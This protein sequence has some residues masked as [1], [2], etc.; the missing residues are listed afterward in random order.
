MEKNVILL[1]EDDFLN[2]RLTKKI[3]LEGDYL[4]FEGKNKREAMDILNSHH[5]DLAILDINLGSD[6]VDGIRLGREVQDR[7]KIPL[8]YLTAY[9]NSQVINRAIQTD[10]YAYLTKPFKPIDLITT[11]ELALKHIIIS[12][13]AQPTIQ[14]KEDDYT[15]DLPISSI[16][17]I[18]SNGNYLL[19]HT[20]EKTYKN[21]LTMKQ[22]LALLPPES[23]LQI[24]RA[25]VVNKAKIE[26]FN[27]KS[28]MVGNKIIPLSR[29]YKDNLD[30]LGKKE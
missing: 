4:I 25:Y 18:E 22:V 10:P 13:D 29:N 15:L 1:I 5:I 16:E 28:V 21:R 3:L 30:L 12:S 2:R 23:F 20:Y 26:K 14:V 8:I 17:Y 27:C 24:H 6:S 9:D 7:F 19:F 11:V